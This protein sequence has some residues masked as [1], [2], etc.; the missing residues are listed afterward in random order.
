MKTSRLLPVLLALATSAV[1]QSI[2]AAPVQAKA[3]T[4][5]VDPA[6]LALAREVISVM[7]VDRMFD[8]MTAQMRQMAAQMTPPM[9]NLT[10]EQ[11]AR[12]TEFQDKVMTLSME[13]AK[14]LL[15]KMDQIYAD[16]YSEQELKTMKAFFS[17]SEGQSMLTKQPQVLAHL[18]PFIQEMQQDL[19]PKVQQLAKQLKEDEAKAEAAAL[20]PAP[21]A[22]PAA[23]AAPELP[24]KR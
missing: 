11:K 6:K 9:A 24:V 21:A 5:P 16:V 19:M 3:D 12:F 14:G 1:A 18:R 8:G 17:S 23:P 15:G 13:A 7:H 22:T 2:P 10:A 20:P 4:A